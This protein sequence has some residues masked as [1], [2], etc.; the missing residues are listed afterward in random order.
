MFVHPRDRSPSVRAWL[1]SPGGRHGAGAT[2][3]HGTRAACIAADLGCVDGVRASAEAGVDRSALGVGRRGGA[4]RLSCRLVGARRPRR[5]IALAHEGRCGS[6][7]SAALGSS[8]PCDGF[9]PRQDALGG[10]AG[11]EVARLRLL[12][13]DSAALGGVPAAGDGHRRHGVVAGRNASHARIRLAPHETDAAKPA[14]SRRGETCRTPHS[15]PEK[16]ALDPAA[17]FEL[18][19][20]DGVR[21]DLLPVVTYTWRRRG[22]PRRVPTPGKNSKVAVCGAYRWPDGPFVFSHGPKSVNTAR[23]V[24]MVT[25]L[26][27]RARRTGKRVMLVLDNG[28]GDTSRPKTG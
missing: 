4:D 21:F 18:W 3:G 22:E 2:P 27:H 6:A 9:L 10:G 28:S 14:G 25:R 11:S 16:G 19:F 23:F 5:P 7:G 8:A 13:V 17:D 1:G 20:G 15:T 26:A 24:E 12:P